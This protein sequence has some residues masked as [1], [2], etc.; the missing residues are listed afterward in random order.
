MW[1]T[2]SPPSWGIII[3]LNVLSIHGKD[4]ALRH[5]CQEER[6]FLNT[7]GEIDFLASPI[8]HQVQKLIYPVFW[9]VAVYIIGVPGT[10]F[11]CNLFEI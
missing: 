2:V 11:C 6:K 3:I 9:T 8:L 7:D 4:C 5:S 1:S 10:A